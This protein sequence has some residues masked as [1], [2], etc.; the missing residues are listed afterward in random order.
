MSIDCTPSKL[1]KSAI[2]FT[3]LPDEQIDSIYTYLICQQANSGGGTPNV[4]NGLVNWWK[5]DE[6]AGT[7]AADSAGAATGSAGA[8]VFPTWVPGKI[9]SALSFNGSTT[10]LQLAANTSTGN[11]AFTV[12]AWVFPTAA[13]GPVI[14]DSDGD[15]SK[16]FWLSFTGSKVIFNIVGNT[17]DLE[18]DSVVNVAPLSTWTFILATWSGT[19]TDSSTAHIYANASEVAYSFSR[20]GAGV[21]VGNSGDTRLIG[22]SVGLG[23]FTGILDDVRVYNRV[24]SADEISN[25]YA[26]RGQP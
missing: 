3:G 19:L 22:G 23:T 5:F 6:N 4:T 7:T 15:I 2:Q 13:D 9:N 26:W 21:H 11:G 17:D 24:L 25:L 14:Y 10:K 16:G 12:S 8:F 18:R 20:N 1:V